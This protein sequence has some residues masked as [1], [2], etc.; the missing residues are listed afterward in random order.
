MP[1]ANV[2]KEAANE[3]LWLIEFWFTNLFEYAITFIHDISFECDEM[4]SAKWI[5]GGEF[6]RCSRKICNPEKSKLF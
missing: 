2:H 6:G 1:D 4:G 5:N 3:A